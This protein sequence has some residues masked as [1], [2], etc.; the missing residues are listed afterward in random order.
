[1]KGDHQRISHLLN[2]AVTVLCKNGLQFQSDLKVE[3]VIGITLDNNEVFVVHINEAYDGNKSMKSQPKNLGRG[4]LD[5]TLLEELPGLML[6][7]H[8]SRQPL[9]SQNQDLDDVSITPTIFQAYEQTEKLPSE[10]S[11]PIH[12][13]TIEPTKEN[14]STSSVNISPKC[15]NLTQSN[16]ESDAMPDAENIFVSLG[17]DQMSG[18]ALFDVDSVKDLPSEGPPAKRLHIEPHTPTL[19]SNT[20]PVLP[21]TSCSLRSYPDSAADIVTEIKQ[22]LADQDLD[23]SEFH[24]SSLEAIEDTQWPNTDNSNGFMDENITTDQVSIRVN[25]ADVGS[26]SKC[27]QHRTHLLFLP[28]PSIGVGRQ[29]TTTTSE[30]LLNSIIFICVNPASAIYSKTYVSGML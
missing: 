7:S 12:T 18:S 19:T 4:E 5:A 23:K 29:T 20:L 9:T 22:E 17:L 21:S 2:D 8:Y 28:I 26:Q 11:S 15:E 16:T 27:L 14:L 1:M 10:S 6:G 24:L 25:D 13:I 3:G 30:L